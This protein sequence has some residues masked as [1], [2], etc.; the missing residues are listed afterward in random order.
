[1]ILS[2]SVFLSCLYQSTVYPYYINEVDRHVQATILP[3][4]TDDERGNPAD[5]DESPQV[6]VVNCLFSHI[7]L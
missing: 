5:T 2:R 1:M 7:G 4:Q 6:K 3:P